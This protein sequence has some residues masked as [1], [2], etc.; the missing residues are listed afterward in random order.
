MP[1]MKPETVRVLSADEIERVHSASV[2]LLVGTGVMVQDDILSDRLV[3][4]GCIRS[5]GGNILFPKAVIERLL[6]TAPAAFMLHSRSGGEPLPVGE[7]I[8]RSVAG[9]DA[10]FFLD[11]KTGER[12]AITRQDVADFAWIAEQLPDVDVVGNQG[13]PQD[14]PA[15]TEE[16]NAAAA[17]LESTGK[18]LIVA[19]DTLPAARA[20]YQMVAAVSGAEDIGRAPLVC[21]HVSPS[22]PL[23]WTPKACQI[24]VETVSRGIPF[25]I[26]PAPMSGATSPVT[27][28]GH[29]V[30][31]NTEIL[32][33]YLIAQLLRE[34]HP[35]AY[36]NAH[37]IFNLREGNPIIATPETMLL[38]IAGVQMARFYKIPSHSI[39][40]DTDS[41]ISDGQGA[42]EKALTAAV[43]VQAGADFM[44]NLGMFSTGCAVSFA[45]LVM[46]AEVFGLL[47]RYR[48]GIE[49]SDDTL[50][51]D[52]ISK[53]GSWGAFLEEEHTLAHYRQENWYPEVSCRKLFAPW[54][55]A[56]GKEV[57]RVAHEKAL[58]LRDAPRRSFLDAGQKKEVEKILEREFR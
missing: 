46:D 8:T 16:A 29:L 27:L 44:V 28:A 23:R 5:S 38:R 17:L 13:I 56:G 55:A 34:G 58:R 35:V 53:V 14:V 37:T 25:L 54:R 1:G 42:W 47:K 7:G 51:V 18:H 26:L 21:C 3:R 12:R 48:R 24:I 19:P 36:C 45:Q 39:G 32:S 10:P 6:G 50:A 31:H 33:G 41:H 20:I 43:C 4:A 30:V 2:K 9:F 49:V 52:L 40:F 11:E 22:L 57:A 15:G